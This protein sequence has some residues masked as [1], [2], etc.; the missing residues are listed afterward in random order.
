MAEYVD[1]LP[2]RI[3]VDNDIISGLAYISNIYNLSRDDVI[4][5][6]ISDW[7]EYIENCI[8]GNYDKIYIDKYDKRYYIEANIEN[9]LWK[10]FKKSCSR[11]GID[12]S[13]AFKYALSEFLNYI[14][15]DDIGTI[16]K[17]YGIRL[18]DRF[19]IDEFIDDMHILM[20]N[21]EYYNRYFVYII[22]NKDNNI[23]YVGRTAN[24]YWRVMS[25]VS[26]NI[27]RCPIT[28]ICVYGVD[29]FIDSYILEK[30]FMDNI[31]RYKLKN[32]RMI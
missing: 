7:V 16:S 30:Y 19:T 20:D 1:K 24:I 2:R 29:R 13:V 8:D 17:G 4:S 22:Y 14:H 11:K 27:L 9:D 28:D 12:L 23:C 5:M 21:D 15:L 25:H 18:I 3:F 6:I 26:S 10:L 31:N 32:I